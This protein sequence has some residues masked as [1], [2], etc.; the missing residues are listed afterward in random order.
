DLR[1][2]LEYPASNRVLTGITGGP[3]GDLYVAEFGPAPHAPNS[4]RITALAPDGR[5][6]DA[7]TDLNTA[8]GVAVAE[9]GTQYAIEFSSGER[10]ASSGRLLRRSPDG[11]VAVL[12]SG[13]NFP[14]AIALAADG[15]IFL[16]I[17]GHRS[18]DGSGQVVRVTLQDS[19][20]LGRLR[21]AL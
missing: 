16:A 15:S 10:V 3:Q 8:I 4:A 12:A 13:L 6:F 21:W 19:G 1:R 7:W 2:L 17:N 9:D 11:S 20:P 5:H 18:E 14:T